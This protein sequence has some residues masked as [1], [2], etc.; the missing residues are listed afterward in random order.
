MPAEMVSGQS[1]RWSDVHGQLNC[2]LHGIL[3]M[4][5]GQS[6]ASGIDRLMSYCELADASLRACF[7]ALS[8]LPYC[9]SPGGVGVV[10]IPLRT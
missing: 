7:P 8:L 6:G 4:V 2:S 10:G 9:G 3:A 5:N 1:H